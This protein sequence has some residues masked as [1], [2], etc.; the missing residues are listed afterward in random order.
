MRYLSPKL[1]SLPWPSSSSSSRLLLLRV[2]HFSSSAS[3]SSSS[4]NSYFSS[5]RKEDESRNVKVS[6]WWDFE[7]CNVPSGINV[8]RIAPTITAAIRANGMKG[9][10]EITAFGDMLQ[11]SKSK[12]EAL[13]S[14]GINLNHI[15]RGG[16]NSADRCLLI[17]LM[18]WVSQNPPPAHLFLIS[19]DKD[20]ATILHRLRM[21]NYNILLAGPEH[22]HG[23]L[24]S[25]AS[26]MWYWN[27][28]LRGENLDGKYFNQPPDGPYGSWYGHYKVPLLDPF[29]DPEQSE[30][31][32]DS[33][34]KLHP[35]PRDLLKRIRQILKS[36][37]KGLLMSELRNK[38]ER[39]GFS[40][41]KE[42]YG[43][44]KFLPF[45]AAQEDILKVKQ[46]NH[47]QFIVYGVYQK[48]PEAF[49][50]NEGMYS[51]P[52]SDNE[53][54]DANAPSKLSCDERSLQRSPEKRSISPSSDQNEVDILGKAY[55][56]SPL[57]GNVTKAVNA[58]EADSSL[59]PRDEKIVETINPPESDGQFPP[60]DE[61]I[62]EMADAPESDGHPPALVE[63]DSTSDAGF[64]RR[65]WRQWFQS[66][67]GD[68]DVKSC[69]DQEKYGTSAS[70]SE[71][72]S[73]TALEKHFT[74]K[75]SSAKG[76]DEDKDSKSPVGFVDLEHST[77][78]STSNEPVLDRGTGTS[79]AFLDRIRNWCQF[80]KSTSDFDKPSD[81]SSDK[82][83]VII[84]DSGKELFSKDSFWNSMKSFV[85]TPEGSLLVSESKA[86]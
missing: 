86:R 16:K 10:I 51:V 42:Y 63:E 12:Q 34:D 47:G 30:E 78:H 66:K 18:L 85:Q 15:P 44:K 65:M 33:D 23:V 24:S 36:H 25:A 80:W 83:N 57:D 72:E 5:R 29:P 64:F 45:L 56:P 53:N 60:G 8:F 40:L 49:E 32:S 20:F 75:D 27:D 61:K 26:I 28:L 77:S 73:D 37:P 58:T 79:P 69:K 38:L 4:S 3:S 2:S 59:P 19:G 11:L 81:L 35:V 13:S 1:P 55:Q 41:D 43:Y 50:G 22:T 48:V 39:S 54:E 67:S 71:K 6:V 74:S 9:P 21:S 70:G 31:S 82:P 84:T 17:N 76:T 68:F 52:D 62:V 46:G 7:N 14:T